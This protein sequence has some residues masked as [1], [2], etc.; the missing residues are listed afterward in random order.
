MNEGLEDCRR[1]RLNEGRRN[2]VKGIGS[3]HSKVV[4]VGEA[5]GKDEDLR[6]E[7]FV[8]RSGKILDAALEE[9][10]VSREDVY[11][12]NLVK[13]RP[14][15]NRRPRKDEV[16]ACR[17]HLVEEL[18]ALNP[19]VVCALGQTV[20]SRLLGV[21]GNMSDSVG[22]EREVSLGDL[23]LRCIV[24]FHPA[25]CLYQRKNTERFARIVAKCIEAAGEG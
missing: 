15:E 14:P 12:T 19:S 9:A 10:D 21:D 24:N 23:R 4:F 3:V 17:S 1:C 2:V 20:A 18:K 13:C 22:E 16:E 7:P 6:G 5:P 8:G 11:I 25:A